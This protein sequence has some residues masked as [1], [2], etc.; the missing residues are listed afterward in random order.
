M[1]TP[2]ARVPS[3]AGNHVTTPLASAAGPEEQPPRQRRA[4]H[5]LPLALLMLGGLTAGGWY[6]FV[7]EGEEER[8]LELQGNI[9]IRQ[10]NLS[11]KVDGRIETLAVDEGDTVQGRTGGRDSGQALF[12][13]R[14]AGGYVPCAI[15]SPRHWRSS[16][17]ARGRRRSPRRGPRRA[18]K[19]A[20]LAQAKARLRA[21]Q[22]AGKYP[23][24]VSKQDLVKYAAQLAVAEADAKFAHESQQLAEIG[25]R[26]EDIDAARALLAQ[27]TAS[28]IQIER[29]LADSQPGRAQRR[30]H[31]HSLS[32]D[33]G[34]RSGRRDGLHAD[35]GLPGLGT[36]LRERTRPGP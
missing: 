20:T 9:D 8:F 34:D 32:R 22:G 36:H 21:V 12:R 17:T 29:K 2:K 31:P 25:P 33:R 18:A 13:G 23:G 6:V 15:I 4:W 3:N 11:F 7:R 30:L 1:E 19:E 27:E 24:A 10:V 16:N 28:I 14:T 5:R 35:P 26:I